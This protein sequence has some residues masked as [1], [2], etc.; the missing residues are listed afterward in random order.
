MKAVLLGPIAPPISGPSVKNKM[1]KDWIVNN[2]KTI[3]LKLFNTYDVRN[4]DF[5]SVFKSLKSF[6]STR[7]II[8]SVSKKGRLLIIPVCWLFRKKIILFPAGGSFDDEINDLHPLIK[9]LFLRCCKNVIE[10]YSQTNALKEGLEKLGF[11]KVIYFPN[12][13][14]NKG[15]KAC[16]KIENQEFKIIY[17]SKIREGKGPLLLIEAIK[18]LSNRFEDINLSLNFYGIIEA[19]F[20]PKFLEAIDNSSFAN[21]EGVVP[22][23]KV[24]NVIAQHNLFILPT[25]FDEGVPGAVIEAMLTGIPIIVSE[26]RA[27]RELIDDEKSGLIVPQNDIKA[28]SKAIQRIASDLPLRESLSKEALNSSVRYDL[29]NN[30]RLFTNNLKNI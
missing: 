20:K 22:F 18:Q 12:P 17:I 28:L 23:D 13:R 16:N 27:S 21:Y 19:E 6:I 2:D 8:L 9:K 4:R 29:D 26:F 25:L 3:E 24:Q 10:V 7:I 5:N 1:M 14:I 11:Q 30:M 15:L